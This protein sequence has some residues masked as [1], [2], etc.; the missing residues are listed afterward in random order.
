MA[1]K[2]KKVMEQ[3]PEEAPPTPK[4]IKPD[5]EAIKRLQQYTKRVSGPVITDMA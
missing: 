1:E 4:R 5:P 3:K 2:S